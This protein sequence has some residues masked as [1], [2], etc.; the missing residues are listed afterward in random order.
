LGGSFC[1]LKQILHIRAFFG[2]SQNAVR[3]QLWSAICVYLATGI[4]RKEL[5]LTTNLTTFAQVLSVHAL[6]KVPLPELFAKFDTSE[7]YLDTP[8]QLI[9]NEL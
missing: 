4:T 5:G 2:T 6:S 1:R 3:L 9:F 7:T 8:E